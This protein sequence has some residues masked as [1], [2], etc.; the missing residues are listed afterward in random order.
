MSR[1]LVTGGCGFI[2]S[3]LVDALLEDGHA[4]R[5][6]DNLSSGSPRHHRPAVELLVGDIA[7]PLTLQEATRDI[8]G[9][10]HLAAVASVTRC[11]QAWL[12]SHRSNL[13][14]TVGLFE[15]ATAARRRRFPVVYAS[16]AAVY[17]EQAEMPLHEEMTIRPR[18]PY[19]A[20]KA[21]CELH[22]RA[23][24]SARGLTTVG[25]RFFNV[26]G[27]RQRPDSP[28]SG[29][30]SVLADRIARGEP[31]L[32]HGDGMQTRDFV[33]VEDVIRAL[34]GAMAQARR[35]RWAGTARVYNVCS[36]QWT[37][38]IELARMLMSLCGRAVPMVHTP[39][40]EGDIRHSV[41][42]PDRL[43][44]E[45]G[46]RPTTPL[47]LGLG[48]T[49]DALNEADPVPEAPAP[50]RDLDMLRSATAARALIRIGPPGR[51][52]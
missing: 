18:S 23:G 33:F 21:A 11:N 15:A 34:V 47:S 28:Y 36:G 42:S 13:S 10:F 46:V 3:H 41:G 26:Y 27:P 29:V 5:V 20:D 37:R 30:I 14:A 2:G 48:R 22:A 7:D 19:G 32:I 4:I 16:S 8:D 24:A 44:R 51:P 43:A 49:L 17:G 39:P 6:V 38:V 45:V 50:L 35:R 25:L 12:H 31:V 52:R 9:C 1:Y 40:R